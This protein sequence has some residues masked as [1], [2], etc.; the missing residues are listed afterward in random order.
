VQPK[1][2]TGSAVLGELAHDHIAA[3]A[4]E[5]RHGATFASEAAGVPVVCA[6]GGPLPADRDSWASVY[7]FNRLLACFADARAGAAAG[8]AGW[9]LEA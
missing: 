4:L 6:A 2:G 3:P 9:R 1:G 5:Q 8:S 7:D